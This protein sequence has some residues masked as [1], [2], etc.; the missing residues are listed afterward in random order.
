MQ[1]FFTSDLHFHHKRILEFCKNTR[2][3]CTSVSE[4]NEKIIAN[5]NSQVSAGDIVYHLGDFCFGTEDETVDILT[6]LNG[7]KHFIIG[8]HDAV[9][10]RPRVRAL[11]ADLKD[12]KE[13]KLRDTKICLFHFPM[14]EW[15]QCH[16]GSFHL[17]GHVH[18]TY[19]KVR[20]KSLNVG[21]DARPDGDM[22]L[23]T[24]QEIFDF[25]NLQETI[26]HH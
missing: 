14:H 24:E 7:S 23:W 1:Y 13:I 15:H 4:M 10:R 9:L 5:W 17:F 3:G 22:L 8:N 18:E 25:M 11:L 16:R 21:L 6:L 20:G 26:S 19:R 2:G 12:Y